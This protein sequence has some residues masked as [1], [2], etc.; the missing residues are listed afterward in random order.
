MTSSAPVQ[1][2]SQN[3]TTVMA[4]STTTLTT[5]VNAAPASSAQSLIEQ[6]QGQPMTM[7]QP[8]QATMTTPAPGPAVQQGLEVGAVTTVDMDQLP[9]H[10]DGGG[11]PNSPTEERSNKKPPYT[12]T[13]LITQALKD[14]TALTVSGIYNWIT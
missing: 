10:E 4:P 9:T 8:E 14:Q 2:A 7:Y 13:E 1:E 12:Y 3:L 11:S 5:L 6:S